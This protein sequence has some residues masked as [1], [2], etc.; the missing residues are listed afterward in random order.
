MIE[1]GE[2]FSA[3]DELTFG[4][5]GKETMIEDIRKE[6]SPGMKLLYISPGENRVMTKVD[7]QERR[8]SI[9]R[10]V[11]YE[12]QVSGAAKFELP[13]DLPRAG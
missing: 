7:P 8:K 1:V 4:R 13:A 3:R 12:A 9:Y 2:A 11:L 5:Q 10:S 6:R